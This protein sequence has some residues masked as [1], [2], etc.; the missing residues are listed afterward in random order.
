MRPAAERWRGLSAFEGPLYLPDMTPS[1]S[2]IGGAIA[3]DLK[4]TAWCNACRH[5]AVL[6]L[7]A[8]ARLLGPDPRRAACRPGAQAALLGMRLARP[9][10]DRE[11]QERRG[12]QR[13]RGALSGWQ[14]SVMSQAVHRRRFLWTENAP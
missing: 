8:L 9:V 12:G 11:F 4:I 1:N 14:W 7:D 3:L 13:R 5:S 6:D 10:A 2:T